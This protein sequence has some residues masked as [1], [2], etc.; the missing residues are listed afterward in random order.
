MCDKSLILATFYAYPL[1]DVAAKLI[2]QT[3]ININYEFYYSY[4]DYQLCQIALS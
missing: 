3:H 2:F 4:Q 1:L